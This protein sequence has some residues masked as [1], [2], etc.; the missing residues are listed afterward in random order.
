MDIGDLIYVILAIVFTIVGAAN[1][2]RKRK[3]TFKPVVSK[4]SVFEELF[5]IEK[6]DPIPESAYVEEEVM[7]KENVFDLETER[8]RERNEYQD[9][10]EKIQSVEV[11][12][13]PTKDIVISPKKKKA[14]AKHNTFLEELRNSKELKKAVLYAEILSPKF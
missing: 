4:P 1:K 5:E 3:S 9:Y 10:L 7:P 13:V 14:L 12:D 6:E 2:K 11:K 8:I